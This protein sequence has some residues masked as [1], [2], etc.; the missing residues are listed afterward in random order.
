MLSPGSGFRRLLRSHHAGTKFIREERLTA[1]HACTITSCPSVHAIAFCHYTVTGANSA[2]RTLVHIALTSPRTRAAPWVARASTGL[3]PPSLPPSPS[4]VHVPS[5]L[6][7]RLCRFHGWTPVRV[8]NPLVLRCHKYPAALSP[9]NVHQH[10]PAAHK[11]HGQSGRGF[12][13]HIP[14]AYSVYTSS[15]LYKL[16]KPAPIASERPLLAFRLGFFDARH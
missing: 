16:G 6:H 7:N 10:Q 15:S 5:P 13:A 1:T 12:S 9:E 11:P 3:N 8:H 4:L 2:P 14:S